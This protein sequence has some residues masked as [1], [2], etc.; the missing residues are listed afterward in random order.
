MSGQ[1]R[2]QTKD[3][4]WHGATAPAVGRRA[5]VCVGMRTIR[6]GSDGGREEDKGYSARRRRRRM[7][8][9]TRM[10]TRMT[11]DPITVAGSLSGPSVLLRSCS[12]HY[13]PLGFP[14]PIVPIMS[15]FLIPIIIGWQVPCLLAH[16]RIRPVL[17]D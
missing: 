5:G 16:Y 9:R 2:E 15:L 8:M 7:R 12:G 13:A 11:G 14:D 4:Q 17:K 3:R 1:R 10:R 6:D